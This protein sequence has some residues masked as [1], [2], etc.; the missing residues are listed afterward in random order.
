M[1]CIAGTLLHPRVRGLGPCMMIARPSMKL[2][3]H[4]KAHSDTW[5]GSSL[6]YRGSDR[7]AASRMKQVRLRE[8]AGFIS[9]M[10][11]CL[12]SV[13]TGGTLLLRQLVQQ[14]LYSSCWPTSRTNTNKCFQMDNECGRTACSSLAACEGQLTTVLAN[15]GRFSGLGTH[16]AGLGSRPA[17]RGAV[18]AG[19]WGGGARATTVGLAG[20]RERHLIAAHPTT[21]PSNLGA[22]PNQ[23]VSSANP[24]CLRLVPLHHPINSI[25]VGIP[26]AALD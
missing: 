2:P 15:G 12:Q 24:L 13:P 8:Y 3:Q 11:R 9:W 26:A 6:A 20:A 4:L 16:P 5:T 21:I 25:C 17:C 22:A 7:Q 18:G 23:T 1:D 10:S 19:A 14:C